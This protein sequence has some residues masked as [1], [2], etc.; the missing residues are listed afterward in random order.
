MGL[1]RVK[2]ALDS[3]LHRAHYVPFTYCAHKMHAVPRGLDRV[4]WMFLFHVIGQ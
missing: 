1:L 4:S 2:L 3:F